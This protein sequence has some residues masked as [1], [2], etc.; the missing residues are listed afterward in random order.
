MVLGVVCSLAGAGF[1][2]SIEAPG[3]VKASVQQ[4]EQKV[5]DATQGI[6]QALAPINLGLQNL[7]DALAQQ[8]Q[9]NKKVSDR[10]DSLSNSLAPTTP[11]LS[12]PDLYATSAST[13]ANGAFTILI[14]YRDT[15]HD[16][17]TALLSRL[18]A[19]GFQASAIN[20]S[21]A[22]VQIE[23]QPS[24]STYIIPTSKGADV[25]DGVV[26]IV[27]ATVPASP[28]KVGNPWPLR[29]GDVQIYMF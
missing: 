2:A 5:N 29:R 21:L 28:V 7:K 10:I 8:D 14:F 18:T 13:K 23:Q 12:Q 22:E 11:K 15:R 24:G 6:S 1:L 26:N 27:K 25:V 16:D 19:A 20:T 4:V 3:G 9:F 17:A